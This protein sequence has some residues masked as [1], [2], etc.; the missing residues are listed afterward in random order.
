MSPHIRKILFGDTNFDK[1]NWDKYKKAVIQRVSERG[2]KEEINEI[3]PFLWSRL[4][5][6]FD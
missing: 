4:Q 1:I 5:Y 2:N 3:K 6:G